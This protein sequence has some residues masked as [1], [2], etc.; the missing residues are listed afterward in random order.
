MGSGRCT[1]GYLQMNV[2]ADLCASEEERTIQRKGSHRIQAIL[3]PFLTCCVDGRYWVGR[4]QGWLQPLS[5]LRATQQA[6]A[7]PLTREHSGLPTSADRAG[8]LSLLLEGII[9]HSTARAQF[10]TCVNTMVQQVPDVQPEGHEVGYK[11][12][13]G[14]RRPEQ[15]LCL[16]SGQG[17]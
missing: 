14:N 1:A 15:P 11:V 7:F 10:L 13:T 12:T 4:G 9:S 8:R 3:N 5:A 2:T 6:R 17:C 16:T